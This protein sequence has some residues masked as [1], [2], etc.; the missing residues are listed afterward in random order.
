LG[1]LEQF[2]QLTDVDINN[3]QMGK[4]WVDDYYLEGYIFA[5][6][7]KRR[8]LSTNLTAIDLTV[9]CEKGNWQSEETWK[10][11]ID[12]VD[13]DPEQY[14]GYGI[15]Y[16]YDYPYN[17][18][19][20]FSTNTILHESYMDTDFEIT[21][22]GAWVMEQG[23]PESGPKITIAGNV[24]NVNYELGPDDYMKINSKTKT[25]VVHRY[26]GEKINVFMYR[27]KNYNLFEKIRG[28]GNPVIKPQ[29]AIVDVKLFYERSEPKYTEAKWT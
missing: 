15:V 27:N 8:Y 24:Y 11:K 29:N 19:A 22:Y 5:S 13:E 1:N 26:N 28:G 16:P 4:L 17:Y 12:H 3:L 23:D 10:F 6:D 9:V 21:F 20:P 2:L 25:A 7:K 14:T 18:S